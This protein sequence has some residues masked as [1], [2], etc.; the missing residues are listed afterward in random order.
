MTVENRARAY[1]LLCSA[2]MIGLGYAPAALAQFE[3]N[4]IAVTGEQAPGSPDGQLFTGF[5][6]LALNNQGQAAFRAVTNFNSE[7][8]FWAGSATGENV[9]RLVG[10]GDALPGAPN[11][12]FDGSSNHLF[13]LSDTGHLT[14]RLLLEGD[15]IDDANDSGIWSMNVG[16]GTLTLIGRAGDPAPGT[17]TQY[18]QM[19]ARTRVNDAGQVL[20]TAD[21]IGVSNSG[22]ENDGLWTAPAS[23][24]TPALIARQADPAPGF[25]GDAA[26]SALRTSWQNFAGQIAFE[27]T[28]AGTGFDPADDQGIWLNANGSG[29]ELVV[30]T[31]D[32]AAG[33][34][35]DAIFE[36]L[37]LQHLDD[38]GR[39]WFRAEMTGTDIAA[40]N[41]VGFWMS[42]APTDNPTL[43]LREGDPAPGL[44]PDVTFGP[45]AFNFAA[46]N[47]SGQFV[48]LAQLSGPTVTAAND[49]SLWL[50]SELGM[51]LIGREGDEFG[52]GLRPG[53]G[54]PQINS[55]GQIA[56]ILEDNTDTQTLWATLPD[57]T[58]VEVLS[59]GDLVA[60]GDEM[61]T[62]AFLEMSLATRGSFA[63]MTDTGLLGFRASFTDGSSALMTTTIPEPSSAAVLLL[64]TAG[65]LG[66]R[67]RRRA[68]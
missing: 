25:G 57:G 8:G 33:V 17:G 65:V 34:G 16:D 39:V 1:A 41:D 4:T 30:R 10:S 26:F 61:K 32:A 3:F 9:F 24:G 67:R 20:Y 42:A 40:T 46:F 64:A 47:P 68:V 38:T 21:L 48:V 29:H 45:N 28:V 59:T 37:R 51:Q 49:T 23:G 5:S 56:I 53:L 14:H 35:G 55:L 19:A 22:F 50:G 12:T 27:A 58:L 2:G 18:D 7:N 66:C 15:G 52:E 36:S 63:S 6:V 11:A 62:V 43:I 60:V 44:G 31:G 13:N 54:G